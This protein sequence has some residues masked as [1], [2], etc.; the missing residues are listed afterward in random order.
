MKHRL[1]VSQ[2]RAVF[3]SASSEF[4][5]TSKEDKIQLLRE[6][7]SDRKDVFGLYLEFRYY[8]DTEANRPDISNQAQFGLCE[9]VDILLE[10]NE[11]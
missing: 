1:H 8:Y 4:Q 11:N 5:S 6:A 10:R 9:L 7:L 3:D 2:L